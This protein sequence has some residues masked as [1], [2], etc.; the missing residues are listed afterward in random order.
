M[1]TAAAAPARYGL[2]GF[3]GTLVDAVA[4]LLRT[5]TPHDGAAELLSALPGRPPPLPDAPRGRPRHP[6]LH[7]RRSLTP[8]SGTFSPA[9]V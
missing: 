4:H 8:C 6:R 3:D 2:F 9:G 7:H 5:P 1:T